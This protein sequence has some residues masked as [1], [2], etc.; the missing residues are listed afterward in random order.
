MP[1][2]FEHYD[3]RGK[4]KELRLNKTLY[5]LCQRPRDFCKD[6]SQKLI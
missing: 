5:G 6:L 3:K 2:G 4:R 1:K